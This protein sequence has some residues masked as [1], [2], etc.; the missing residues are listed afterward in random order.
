MVFVI[1]ELLKYHERSDHNKKGLKRMQCKDAKGSP[2]NCLYKAML[3][4][5]DDVVD[6]FSLIYINQV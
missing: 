1:L 5:I 3:I 6:F 4:T 2:K